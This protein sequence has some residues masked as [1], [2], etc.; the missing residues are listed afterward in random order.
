MALLVATNA[1]PRLW[2]KAGFAHSCSGKENEH[3]PWNEEAAMRARFGLILLLTAFALSANPVLAAETPRVGTF[4][5]EVDLRNL[6][7]PTK[8]AMRSR[9]RGLG[10]TGI[11]PSWSKE[12]S[13]PKGSR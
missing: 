10:P 13:P 7:G 12:C 4:A 2:P 9:W 8:G 11:Q 5:A 6:A 3:R 1:P